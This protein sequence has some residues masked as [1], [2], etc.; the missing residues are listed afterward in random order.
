MIKINALQLI[1][2]Q[3]HEDLFLEFND[4]LNI[5]SGQSDS[6][7]TAIFRAIAWLCNCSN[8]SDSDYRKEGTKQTSVKVWLNNGF[9]IERVRSASINRYI[10]SKEGI[11]NKVFDKF[12]RDLPQEISDILNFSNIIIDNEQI[13]LNF[14]DQDNSN[15]LLDSQYTDL[16][17][18]QL[19]NL[20]TGA[21]LLDKLF[22]QFNKDILQIGRDLKSEEEKVDYLSK[23]IEIKEVEKEQLEAIHKK[24]EKLVNN[25]KVTQENYCKYKELLELVKKNREI[26]QIIKNKKLTIKIPEYIEIKELT[27][28]IEDFNTKKSLLNAIT[29]TNSKIAT[30]LSKKAEIALSDIDIQ[31]ICIKIERFKC[32]NELNILLSENLSN[33][34]SFS[35][36]KEELNKKIILLKESLDEILE[37]V[38][39][40]PLCEQTLTEDCKKRLKE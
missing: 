39:I 13:D 35:L 16:F 31:E 11:E 15:F 6:G 38:E 20:L 5:I 8:I 10:L 18:A 40:C 14:A 12:G 22:K 1:N 27:E 21:D 29:D 34:G 9:Q 19:F 25:L 2:F 7:K 26:T 4:N 30:T 33:L 36:Q 32:L 23:D 17:K 37:K 3:K 28:K 24:A